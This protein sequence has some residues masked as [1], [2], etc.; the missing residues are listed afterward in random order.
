MKVLAIAAH[1]DDEVLGPGAT[2]AALRSRGAEIHVAI[3]TEGS[4]SQYPDRPELVEAKKVA[5]RAA[6]DALGGGTLHFGD[7]PD[8]KLD[9]IP[10]VRVN[11]FIEGV[12]KAVAPDVVFTH[13]AN[14]LNR[15]H[16]IVHE[17]S[18]VACRPGPQRA[19]CVY[20]Y[21]ILGVT[22]FGGARSGFVARTFF[23]VGAFLPQKLA[24]LRA[25]EV[26]VR[27]FPHPRSPEA[28]EAQGRACGVLCGRPWAEGFDL[29]REV[30]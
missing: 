18:L 30:R 25:Y 24:A 28:I 10:L 14:D 16:R 11:A 15:D 26:E 5:A 22:N 3:V 1:P 9:T 21:D 7:L 27:P 29:V 19:M 12:V 4:T 13:D 20:T 2:L 8:M 17:A 6:L 23:D